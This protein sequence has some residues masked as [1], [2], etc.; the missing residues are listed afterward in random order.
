MKAFFLVGILTLAGCTSAG[1]NSTWRE[2]ASRTLNGAAD[3]AANAAAFEKRYCKDP[4][5][6]VK[7]CVMK[8][9]PTCQQFQVCERFVKS[10]MTFNTSILAAQHALLKSETTKSKAEAIV[11]AAMATYEPV[12]A[13]IEG[14]AK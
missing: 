14:W 3:L 1:C 7:Q 8:K 5:A 6:I 11:K 10:L 4:K 13:T 12:K 9:D 2:N